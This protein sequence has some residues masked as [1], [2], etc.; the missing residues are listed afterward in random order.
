MSYRI[1]HSDNVEAG[2]GPH[3]AGSPFDKRISERLGLGAF[4]MYKVQL[5]AGAATEPHDHVS[6]GVEDAYAIVRGSGWLVVDGS[7]VPLQEGHFVAVSQE[8]VRFVRAGA[9]GC[10]LIAV[11]A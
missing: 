7:E 1:V 4:E 3:P 5:P 6:D 2:R 11:C 10:D 8:S 9:D